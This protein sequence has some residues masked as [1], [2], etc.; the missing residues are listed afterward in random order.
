MLLYREMCIG[1]PDLS[2]LQV[3]IEIITMFYSKWGN[4]QLVFAILISYS[5]RTAGLQSNVSIS[6]FPGYF[7]A[8]CIA[9]S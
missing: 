3:N 9:F 7:W 1:D 2:T 4:I 5:Y 8:V 6:Q